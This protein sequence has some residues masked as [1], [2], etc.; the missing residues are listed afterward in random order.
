[1]AQPL[2]KIFQ[3]NLLSGADASA[4]QGRRERSVRA[5]ASGRR[6]AENRRG[7]RDARPSDG[8]RRTLDL[9]AAAPAALGL[10]LAAAVGWSFFMGYMV[11]RGEDPERGG[12]SVAGLL[13][14]GSS[15]TVGA[16]DAAAPLPGAEAL[17]P[18]P[19]GAASGD[20]A[21]PLPPTAPGAEARAAA[22]APVPD[23]EPPVTAAGAPGNAPTGANAGQPAPAAPVPPSAPAYP[24]S[25]PQGESLAAWGI[26]E[27]NAQR[28]P[29]R[30]PSGSRTSRVLTMSF[31]RRPSVDPP[32]RSACAAVWKRRGCA[33]ACARAARCGWC[34]FPCAGA[35]A[36]P[37]VCAGNWRP[38]GL[39]GPFCWKRSRWR[40]KRAARAAA[41]VRLKCRT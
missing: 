11:G 13:L 15:P 17:S 14:P 16:A 29:Q 37:T 6:P 40:K 8:P 23:G 21:P 7:P 4:P 1:M 2:R 27:G 20:G 31:R 19:E 36:M 22:G 32:M 26:R 35:C 41:G 9:S 38:W 24:F 25:R 3:K 5:E 33:R 39:A 18:A 28:E 34:S 12:E 30:R 10:A